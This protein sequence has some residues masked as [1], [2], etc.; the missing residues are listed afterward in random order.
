MLLTPAALPIAS[1]ATEPITEFC[2]D[3]IA[4]ETPTPASAPATGATVMN[5]AV[6][7]SRRRPAPSGPYPSAVCSICA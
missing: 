3:G 6:Y 7:G 2:A 1:A 5:V 4:I